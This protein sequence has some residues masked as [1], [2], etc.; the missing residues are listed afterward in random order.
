LQRTLAATLYC[1][2]FAGS[3]LLGAALL[4][5]L[6]DVSLE[7]DEPELG[8]D[9]VALDEELELGLE[10]VALEELEPDGED[11]ELLE[12]DAEPDM[13]PDGEDG[14]VLLED[15]EP[16]GDLSRV[17]PGPVLEF[18]SQPYRP[19]TA[20]AIGST[21]NAVFLSKLIW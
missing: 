16:V 9:G 15:D 4:P 18:L 20:T 5:P 7:D 21:T 12:P 10:G 14:A 6:E 11:G 1:D 8:V 3:L 13:E 2:F 17:A 19:V